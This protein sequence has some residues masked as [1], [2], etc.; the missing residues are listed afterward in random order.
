[1]HL[2]RLIYRFNFKETSQIG[3][4]HFAYLHYLSTVI[5]MNKYYYL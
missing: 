1:M 5:I 4:L 2:S 3:Y